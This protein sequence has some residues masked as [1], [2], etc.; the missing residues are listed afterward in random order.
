[1]FSAEVTQRSWNNA[2]P[3]E[4]RRAIRSGL[5]KKHTAGVAPGYVQANLCVLPKDWADEFLL[6][7]HRNPKPCPILALSDPGDPHLPSLGEDLDVRTDL[8][9]Y[10]VFKDGV[11]VEERSDILDLWRDDFVTFAIGCSFSFEE[12]LIEAGVPLKHIDRDECVAVYGTS[13]DCAPAG[14]F[15]GKLVVSMRPLKP[16]DAIRAI[17]I[18]SRFPNV[19]GAP[20]HIGNPE[21]I[22]VNLAKTYL[23]TGAGDVAPDELPVFWACGVTPQSVVENARPPICITHVPGKMLVTDRRNTSLA[24]F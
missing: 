9:G 17:Q 21:M 2:D 4:A 10:R 13:V 12:A 20:V 5:F 16:K 11:F 8:S 23:G 24:S 7:C 18:T 19:H 6:F 1:M 22:G 14:R 15:R 3:R